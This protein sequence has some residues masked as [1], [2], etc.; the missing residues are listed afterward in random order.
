MKNKLEKRVKKLEKIVKK[1]QANQ[2]D[3][4]VKRDVFE[5]SAVGEN[6]TPNKKVINPK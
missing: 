2:E 3:E 6:E 5:C 4:Q 1:L